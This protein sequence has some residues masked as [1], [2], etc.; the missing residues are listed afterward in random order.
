MIDYTNY[1]FENPTT[2][3]II[4]F[5]LY[6]MKFG[7]NKLNFIVM[8][9]LFNTFKMDLIFD[10]KGSKL[11]R[12]AK[13]GNTILKDIDIIN[14]NIKLNLSKEN[15]QLFLMQLKSDTQFLEKLN[16]MDYR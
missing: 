6:S 5:G 7:K 2:N 14:S 13:K 4:I 15:E 11:G 3:L 12:Y 9:N 8:K 10:L 1:L 16:L